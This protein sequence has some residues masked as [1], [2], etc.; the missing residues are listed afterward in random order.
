MRDRN[1]AAYHHWV[2]ILI[3]DVAPREYLSLAE[4]NDMFLVDLIPM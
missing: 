4:S 2:M 1:G 3:D